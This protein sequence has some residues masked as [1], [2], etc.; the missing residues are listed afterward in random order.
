MKFSLRTK[1]LLSYA[2]IITLSLVIL[3]TYGVSV[4][5]E[6]ILTKAKTSLYNEASMIATDYLSASYLTTG[7]TFIALYKTRQHGYY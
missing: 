5:Y 3:N 1:F 4:V 7:S 6:K 2:F